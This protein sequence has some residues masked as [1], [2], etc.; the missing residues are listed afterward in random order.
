MLEA[1]RIPALLILAMAIPA[2]ADTRFQVH[3][4]TRGDVPAGKGQCDIR[5]QVDED[6]EVEVRGDMVAVRTIAGQDA[7]DD[8]S[9]CNGPLP[10]RDLKGFRYEVRDARD[11]IKLL[12]EPSR[13]NNFAA[14]IRIH[15]GSGG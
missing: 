15:D 4:M 14:V 13:R 7:R 11:E 5:L 10:N 2:A 3:R 12:A 9:E 1:M 6:V 8:G